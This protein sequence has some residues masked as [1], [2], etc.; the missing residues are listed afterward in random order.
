MSKTK[1]CTKCGEVKILEEF[2]RN[3]DC[4]DGHIGH[5]K[6]CTTAYDRARPREANAKRHLNRHQAGLSWG[7]GDEV[8]I[9]VKSHSR[10]VQFVLVDRADADIIFK[11]FGT[12]MVLEGYAVS[13]N[14]GR[15]HRWLLGLKKGDGKMV[16]HIDG[17]TLNNHRN[18]LRL[19]TPSQNV[20]NAAKRSDNTS[21][22]TGVHWSKQRKKYRA[23]IQ[24]NGKG[25]CLGF[26]NNLLDAAAARKK[27]ELKYFGE[28]ALI[29]CRAKEGVSE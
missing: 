7:Y 9:I 17:D 16:D 5:C 28:F 23:Q 4:K 3:C 2:H 11:S 20:M 25:K 15:L 14:G 18:N 12:V 26:F 1:K 8:R 27:A 21:G 19:C 6:T 13:G 29:N 22:Y 10:P 24:V